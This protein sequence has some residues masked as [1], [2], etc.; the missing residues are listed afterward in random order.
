[1]AVQL[2]EAPAVETLECLLPLLSEFCIAPPET[3]DRSAGLRFSPTQR[4]QTVVMSIKH[5]GAYSV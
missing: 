4:C 5:L 2:A 3:D 1:M